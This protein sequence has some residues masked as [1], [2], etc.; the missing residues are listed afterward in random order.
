MV[1]SLPEM[2]NLRFDTFISLIR[3]TSMEETGSWKERKVVQE[4]LA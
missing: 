4:G 3:V 1:S 2:V